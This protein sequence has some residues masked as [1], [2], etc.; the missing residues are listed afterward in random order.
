MF[1]IILNPY[2]SQLVWAKKG[3]MNQYIDCRN[4]NYMN[5]V[6][7]IFLSS[8]SI[9]RA[10][11]ISSCG[12]EQNTNSRMIW[13]LPFHK[14]PISFTESWFALLSSC[15]FM[16]LFPPTPP[17]PPPDCAYK[18]RE[19][20]RGLSWPWTWRVE[21]HLWLCFSYMLW[22]SGNYPATDPDLVFL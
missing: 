10:F 3:Y 6:I 22:K 1:D 16:T 21:G 17:H 14:L 5:I 7:L 20:A 18:T 15:Y 13:D 8:S 2:A 19:Y 12:K 9:S 11:I 4:F